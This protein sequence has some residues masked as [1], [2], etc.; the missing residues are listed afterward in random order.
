MGEKHDVPCGKCPNCL[1]RRIS[2]W[3]FRLMQHERTAHAAFFVTLTYNTDHVPITKKGYMSLEKTHLQNYFKRLRKLQPKGSPKISYYACGEYGS[4]RFRP[5]YHIILFNASALDIEKA[6][7]LDNKKLGDIY[8]GAVTAASV[9]YTLKYMCKPSKI[10]MHQ[11]DDRQKEFSLMSKG[12][13][14]EYLSEGILKYHSDD[15]TNRLY[16]NIPDGKKIAMPRYYKDKIYQSITK[17]D[18]TEKIRLKKSISRVAQARNEKE[19][20]KLE[21][22]HGDNYEQ[23]RINEFAAA[24]RKLDNARPSET[25]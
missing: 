16:C 6:W 19:I 2:G 14:A 4:K 22:K 10:P 15:I 18:E 7:S 21:E 9:G 12:I 3:S 23:N 5:H 24:K 13:G 8:I 17:N 11:N 20:Q 25:I 1:K